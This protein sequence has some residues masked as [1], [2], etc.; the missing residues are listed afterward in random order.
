MNIHCRIAGVLHHAINRTNQNKRHAQIHNDR[1]GWNGFGL[2]F[3][4]AASPMEN[5]RECEEGENQAYLNSNCCQDQYLSCLGLTACWVGSEGD[6]KGI[7]GFHDHHDRCK[8]CKN[9]T[10]RNRSFGW[11]VM[12]CSTEDVIITKFQEWSV[13]ERVPVSQTL[14]EEIIEELLPS[15]NSRANVDKYLT[16]NVNSQSHL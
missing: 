10:R 15:T 14:M 8:D 6:S 9:S 5:P 12:K 13:K 16:C 4:L 3:V 11:Y 2:N 1:K 7:Q